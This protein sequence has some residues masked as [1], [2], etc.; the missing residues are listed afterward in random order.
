MNVTWNELFISSASSNTWIW[1]IHIII[2]GD[3]SITYRLIIKPHYQLPVGLIIQLLEH[4]TGI[5]EVMVWGCS[6][7]S[8]AHNCGDHTLKIHKMALS[9]V[10]TVTQI[11]SD[12]IY[13][14]PINNYFL[15]AIRLGI[16][17]LSTT[18]ILNFS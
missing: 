17:L 8:S 6:H 10:P 7:Y 16:I 3:I 9:F 5:A 13:F 18:V 2:Y 4:C 15:Q 11:T 12:T 1:C 14:E